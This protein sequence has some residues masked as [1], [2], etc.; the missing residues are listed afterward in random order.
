MILAFVRQTSWIAAKAANNLGC[1]TPNYLI[2]A[3]IALLGVVV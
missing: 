1:E 2:L 3:L